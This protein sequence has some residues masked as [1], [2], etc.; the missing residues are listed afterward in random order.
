MSAQLVWIYFTESPY[1]VLCPLNHWGPQKAEILFV[2]VGR[3]WQASCELHGKTGDTVL[4]K[5]NQAQRGMQ[6]AE[7]ASPDSKVRDG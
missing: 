2:L 7:V 6:R 5:W 1:R 4:K 3:S